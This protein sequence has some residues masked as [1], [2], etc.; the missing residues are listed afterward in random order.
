MHFAC[1]LRDG[2]A[3]YVHLE[4]SVCA[5]GVLGQPQQFHHVGVV[6]LAEDSHLRCVCVRACVVWCM[7]ASALRDECTFVDV[8]VRAGVR[9]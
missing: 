5:R 3:A 2:R 8:H 7:C 1:T 6:Q 9:E 4:Q